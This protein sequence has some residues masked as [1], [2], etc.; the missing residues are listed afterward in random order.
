MQVPERLAILLA[1]VVTHTVQKSY[2]QRHL[3]KTCLTLR[4]Q[5]YQLQRLKIYTSTV[6]TLRNDQKVFS[7]PS[8]YCNFLYQGI[9]TFFALC[10]QDYHLH[11]SENLHMNIVLTLGMTSSV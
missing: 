11:R 10:R 7:Q 9:N 8:H 4:S 1:V 3:E 6:L 2:F 5:N